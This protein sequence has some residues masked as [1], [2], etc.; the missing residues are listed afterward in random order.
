[1]RPTLPVVVLLTAVL[2]SGPLSAQG[3]RPRAELA[4][5]VAS[6]ELKPGDTAR[7]V[8]HVT[9]PAG[10]HVQA[11]KPKDP[12][13][14]AT[15]LTV[16]PPKGTS[17]VDIVY[18]KPIDFKQAGAPE[19]LAV[20]TEQFDVVVRLKLSATV[21]AGTLTV[22]GHFRYQACNDSICFPPVRT[23]ASWTVVVASK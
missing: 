1:M 6:L 12:A 16:D 11:D 15:D 20:F 2:L 23:D 8:L 21:A 22:P 5:R 18:P 13:L 3:R 10:L 7:L 14:I 19:P 17:L 9:L 4:T